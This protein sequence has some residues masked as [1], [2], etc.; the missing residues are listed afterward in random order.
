MKTIVF[1]HQGSEWY[2]SDKMLAAL[3]VGLDKTKFRVVVVLP[4]S[5]IL[6]NYLESKNI[7]IVYC[8]LAVI[9]RAL[10]TV[11]GL[12]SLPFSLWQN[13]RQLRQVLRPFGK[14]DILHTCT[15]AVLSGSIFAWRYKICHVWHI[16]EMIVNPPVVRRWLPRI[17]EKF[18]DSVPCNSTATRD[19]LISECP[20]ISH[21]AIVIENCVLPPETPSSPISLKEQYNYP[22]ETILLGLVGRINR[23]K[24]QTLLVEAAATLFSQGITNFRVIFIGDV[25]PG[26]D[27]FKIALQKKIA[28]TNYQAYFQIISFQQDIW[29]FWPALDIAVV[30]STEPEP[31]GL[32][33]IEAMYSGKP[34]IAANH[35][36]LTEIVVHEQTGLLFK[37]ND[38]TALADAL[39]KLIFNPDLRISYG[40]SGK[41]RVE[42]HFSENSY[43]Q[44]FDSLYASLLKNSQ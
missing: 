36:G 6:S 38:V 27:E 18:S 7:T 4:Q 24:G 17:I 34:V 23:W 10:F 31:F 35:G 29:A 20:K 41:E 21:K 11:R 32:V 39:K 42:S 2:G 33:A 14:I 16:H 15:L 28:E 25:P 13:L 44:K 12:L 22:S 8:K 43:I 3:V 9:S 5:G 19:L 1:L 40:K 26:Q 30:P 37:P